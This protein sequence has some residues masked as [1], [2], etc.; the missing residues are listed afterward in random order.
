[1]PDQA[2]R[3]HARRE[4]SS[5]IIGM[6]GNLVMGCA[7]IIAGLLSNS[8]A[9]M[10]DGLFSVIGFTSAL[11]GMRIS[12]RLSRSPDKFR[13]FGY[14]A[15]ES[16]FTT[17]RALTVLGLILFAVASA[18]MAI[19]A[20]LVHG[21]AT[22]LNIYPAI[23]YFIFIAVICLALW[24]V[25]YRNW[26]ITGRR[27]D[28]LRLEAKAAVFDGLLTGVAAAGLIGIHLLRDGALAPIA[29]IGD[30]IVV[31]VLCL[32][33]VKHFWTDFML[34]LGELAGTTA[35]P[36][37]IV[38]ARRA[39]RAV[40][41]SMP[42]RLQDFTVMKTGRSYLICVY[43]NPLAPVSAAEVDAL[44]ERLNAAMRPVLEGAE[45]MVILSEQARDG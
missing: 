32:A 42:G 8:T 25:H 20:Y 2:I 23:V 13:P 24:A 3:A 33:G 45:A 14:A 22:E 7:G 35:R 40:L 26:V 6:I 21:E 17:F 27:S 15:E 9:V 30:S 1:M 34:G 19:H 37:T 11:I 5:M 31:L 43:Y 44:T 18:A 16:L 36:E 10:L 38:R 29:P 39:A 4:R 12:Q 28:I 41:Q